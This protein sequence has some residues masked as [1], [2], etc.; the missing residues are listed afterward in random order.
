VTPVYTGDGVSCS[1]IPQNFSITIN[2]TPTV[3][4]PADQVTCNGN[5]SQAVNFSGNGTSYSWNNS[6]TAIG[7]GS[8]GNG[9]IASFTTTNTSQVPISGTVTVTPNFAG[10]SA[11]CPGSPQSF[12]ITVNPTPT[13]NPLA[14]QVICNNTATQSIAFSGT[15]TAY[16]WNNN[17]TGIGLVASGTGNIAAFTAT[18]TSNSNALVATLTA[19]PQY[20]NGGVTCSGNSQQMTITVNPTPVVNPI[21]DLTVC[22][23]SNTPVLNFAGSGTTYNWT[24]NNN[25]IG[26]VASG[27]GLSLASFQATNG[28]TQSV[29][30]L[31]TV[32]PEYTA[33]GVTCLGNS[34]SFTIFL[35]PTPNVTAPGN[36]IICNGSPTNAVIFNGTVPATIYNWTNNIPT[37]GIPASGSGNIASFNAINNGNTAQF[38]QVTITPT[39]IQNTVSCPGA[40]QSFSY[41][42]NPTPS[43]TNPGSQYVCANSTTSLLNFTGTG[44]QYQWSA[45]N[46][47]IGIASS[48]N[49]SISPFIGINATNA[50]AS[51]SITVTPIF[52][53]GISCPGQ[54]ETFTYYVLPIPSAAPINDQSYCHQVSV[55]ATPINGSGTSYNWTNSNTT[56]G[57][58]GSGSNTINSFNATNPGTQA[59]VGNIAVTPIFTFQGQSCNGPQETYTI[60]VNPTPYVNNLNDTLICNNNT[61]AVNIGTNIPSNVSWSATQNNN[62]TGELI[63]TQTSNFINDSLTNTSNSPQFVTYTITPTT[64]AGCV[65]P[66]SILVAQVQPD[67]VLNIPQSIEICSGAGVN[68]VLAANIPSSYSWFCTINNPNVTGESILT[69]TG[70]VIND[71]LVNTSNQNQVVVYAVTPT[72]I[73]GNCIG[74]SQTI[75]V[76]VKPPLALLNQDSVTI[77]SNG[78]VNLNLVA[79][80]AVTFNWYANPNVNVLGETTSIIS[81]SVINDQLVNPTGAVELVQYFVIGTS[82]VNGCSSPIIPIWVFVN[83]TPSVTPNPD[84]N[85]CHNQSQPQVIFNGTATGTNYTWNATGSNVGLPANGGVDS[86][87]AF[88]ASNLGFAPITSLVV[89]DPVFTFNGVSCPG[90]QDTFQIIV[91][92]EPSVFPLNNLTLCEGTLSQLVNILGP[93]GGTTFSWVNSNAAVGLGSTGSGNIPV[94]T[95][96]NPTLAPIQSTVTVTPLFVNGN[97]QCPG[98]TTS[99][100]VTVNP[101]P[102]IDTV[103]LAICPDENVAHTLSADLPSSF[104]WF[105]TPNQLVFNET[106]NPIQ[107]SNFI[108][109]NLVQTTNTP[110]T[111]QYNIAATSLAHGCVGN[112]IVNVQVNPWPTVG[113][114]AL[115]PPYC[116]LTPIAFQNNSVGVNDYLWD[117]GD[118]TNSYLENPTHQFP[119]V[120]TYN[121]T[122][123]ATEPLT[124]CTDSTM[125]PVSISPSPDPGFSY[126]DSIGCGLLDVVFTS[127]VYNPSWNY[128]WSFGDG[129]TTQQV[130]V[131]GYQYTAG[132]CYDVSLSVTNQQGCTTT[133]TYLDVIC[134]YESPV[135]LIGADPT[136]V[137]TFNPYVEF[138]N[139][140]ANATSYEWNFGDGSYGYGYDPNHLYPAEPGDYL[141]SMTALNEV[142]CSDTAYIN[143]H[144]EQTLIYYVPNTFTPNNDEKNQVFKPILTEGYKPGTYLLRIYN[145][146]G[147]IVFESRDQEI[148]WDGGYG[149]NSINCQTGTYTWVLNFQVLQTQEDKEIV[150]HVNLIK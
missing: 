17:T 19:T 53:Q 55:P 65:G 140:S 88:V 148:G 118:G 87:N 115:N 147:E 4:I 7:L 57:L 38:A 35:S 104:T 64:T 67:V 144:V 10:G 5:L 73:Q 99:F 24:N 31:V 150:G 125:L 103:N 54:T 70:G 46:S 23:Q 25:T 26:L 30:A 44:T 51:S 133:E 48:G 60:T 77:C 135:A 75:T 40:P 138:T 6:N 123:V 78:S 2:P 15:G 43:V 106:S 102:N 90:A 127:D 37:I 8:S 146:W 149:P 93:I 29:N 101:A 107:S 45:S 47:S 41:Q 131:V 81:A 16:T 97:T 105:A 126:S 12:T 27:T 71:I 58:V 122:L 139:S 13:L 66:D 49:N 52:F 84:M 32:S 95:A 117:F 1:G 59:L 141:V 94:F 116:D 108:N 89:V 14:S 63:T 69:N 34:T 110:Q 145:R 119:A 136:W 74:S 134:V 121:V 91:N 20:L 137:T 21:N 98:Q 113:F 11:S 56:I 120:G 86:L 114:S 83:P 129:A 3:Q 72:S 100:T 9:N 50:V 80:T 33:N 128:Q 111:V 68:A 61:L 124:G 62:V 85:L 28:S 39:F 96:N 132:G 76:V 92:P 82:V 22:N 130:G 143:I 18:N 79:N 112:G 36:Q 42:I 109:D 142:G